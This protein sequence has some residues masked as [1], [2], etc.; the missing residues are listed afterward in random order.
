MKN[1]VQ[2]VLSLICV[3]Y[4]RNNACKKTV[5]ACVHKEIDN[6]LFPGRANYSFRENG[7]QLTTHLLGS[8]FGS[9]SLNLASK[10]AAYFLR[11]FQFCSRKHNKPFYTCLE[12]VFIQKNET[13][14]AVLLLVLN[15]QGVLTSIWMP[16]TGRNSC[17]IIHVLSFFHLYGAYLWDT[18]SYMYFALSKSVSTGNQEFKD[19]RQKNTYLQCICKTRSEFCLDKC[20]HESIR[21]MAGL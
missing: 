5:F 2:Y 15:L 3:S 19:S 7:L 6:A 20:M 1:I 10:I 18:H 14:F 4:S 11:S 9:C 16:S 21:H 17:N 8:S 13:Q 12:V